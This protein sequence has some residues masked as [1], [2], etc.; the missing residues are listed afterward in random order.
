M[1]LL[2]IQSTSASGRNADERN[3]ALLTMPWELERGGIA[4]GEKKE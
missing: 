4:F 2:L 3:F 1:L